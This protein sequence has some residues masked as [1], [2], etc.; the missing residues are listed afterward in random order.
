MKAELA[1]GGQGGRR[2]IV[3]AETVLVE[4]R[5]AAPIHRMMGKEYSMFTPTT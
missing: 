4:P 3:V 2:D 5:A 1:G